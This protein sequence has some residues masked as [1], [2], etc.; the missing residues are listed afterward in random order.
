MAS[1]EYFL[2]S[3]SIS[4]DTLLPISPSFSSS[5]FSVRCLF[6]SSYTSSSSYLPLLY[7]FISHP[8]FPPDVIPPPPPLPVLG[9]NGTDKMLPI[10]SSINQAIQLPL[11]I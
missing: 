10:E 5:S 3:F 7:P 11:T 8:L 9:Q 6:S 2:S 4:P 1:F